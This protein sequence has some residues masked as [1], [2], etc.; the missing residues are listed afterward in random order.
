MLKFIKLSVIA[1]VLTSLGACETTYVSNN[2]KYCLDDRGTYFEC[3]LINAKED[4]SI[5]DKGQT[6]VGAQSKLFIPEEHFVLVKD[7]AQQVAFDLY[8]KLSTGKRMGAIAVASYVQFDSTLD[9]TN[10][11]GNQM[12][13]FLMTEMQSLGMPLADHK[14]TGKIRVNPDGDSV[15]SRDLSQLKQS[16]DIMYVLSGT[17]IVNSNGV[18]LNSRIVNLES[19]R[20]VASNSKLLPSWLISG[21]M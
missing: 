18:V 8:N 6:V 5:Y 7:Y 17:M 9:T 4:K 12:A 21:M 10:A 19:N 20:I 16:Q 13:E 11:L 1:I 2:S 15:F 14:L 3:G